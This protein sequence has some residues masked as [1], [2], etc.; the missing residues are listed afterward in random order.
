[1]RIPKPITGVGVCARVNL[2]Y[3]ADAPESGTYWA[4]KGGRYF[5]VRSNRNNTKADPQCIE[6]DKNGKVLIK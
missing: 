6:V 3:I 4:H 5:L 1:M 2:G